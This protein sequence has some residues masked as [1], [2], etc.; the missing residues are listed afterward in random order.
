[1]SDRIFLSGMAFEGRHGVTDQERAHEQQIDVDLEVALDL[2]PAGNADDLEQTVDYG[3]LYEA[4]R[5][6]VEE[7]S[8]SLLEGIAEAIATDVLAQHELVERVS[9]SVRKPGV[10]I[11]GR[12]E[13]AGVA[14]ERSRSETS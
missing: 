5:Q 3:R 6:I 1:M 13:W 8:F 9:V 4:C 11:D 10:P 12:V 14:I 2:R 7:R